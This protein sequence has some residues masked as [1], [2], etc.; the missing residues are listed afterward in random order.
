MIDIAMYMWCAVLGVCS[1]LAIYWNLKFIRNKRD[2][3]PCAG[4]TVSEWSDEELSWRLQSIGGAITIPH[5][6]TTS[7]AREVSD[8]IHQL[9]RGPVSV[10]GGIT[11]ALAMIR[12]FENQALDKP[13]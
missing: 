3:L 7:Q 2:Q 11:I 13:K 6:I 5:T 10:G 4:A 8:R 9:A 12:R 1:G